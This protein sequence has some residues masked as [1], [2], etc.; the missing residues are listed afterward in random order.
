MHDSSSCSADNKVHTKQYDLSDPALHHM[1]DVTHERLGLA[2]QERRL[3]TSLYEK[4]STFC[5]FGF[6]FIGR[7][8]SR[9]AASAELVASRANMYS[10]V[11]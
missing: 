11:S 6:F 4:M 1:H 2:M 9:I 8:W 3:R 7:I 5:E 10:S